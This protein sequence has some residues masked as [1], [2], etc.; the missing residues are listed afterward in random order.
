MQCVRGAAERSAGDA[1]AVLRGQA[2]REEGDDAVEDGWVGE[3][4][5]DGR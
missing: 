1:P 4:R 2:R 3:G 5:G